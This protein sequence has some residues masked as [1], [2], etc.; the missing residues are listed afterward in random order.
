MYTNAVTMEISMQW[1]ENRIIFSNPKIHQRNLVP[2]KISQMLWTP[3]KDL[4]YENASMGEIVTEGRNIFE[5]VSKAQ[6]D[7]KRYKKTPEYT[8]R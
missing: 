3:L 8:R 2:S 6:E 7:T 4:T 1:N 5:V